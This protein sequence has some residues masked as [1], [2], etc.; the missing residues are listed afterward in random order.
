MPFAFES[1]L[2]TQLVDE[3]INTINKIIDDEIV[4]AINCKK[5]SLLSIINIMKKYWLKLQE[6]HRSVN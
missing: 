5:Q 2:V 4:K 6:K 1:K 3:T